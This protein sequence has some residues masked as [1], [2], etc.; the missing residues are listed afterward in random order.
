MFP[1]PIMRTLKAVSDDS[2][3]SL[4][5]L[6]AEARRYGRAYIHTCSD[7]ILARKSR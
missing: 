3:T 5:Q 1:F 7:G 4:D 2:L 6:F